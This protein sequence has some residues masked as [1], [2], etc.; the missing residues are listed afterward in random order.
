[1]PERI[2]GTKGCAHDN[3][4][5]TFEF[6]NWGSYVNDEGWFHQHYTAHWCPDHIPEW[7]SEWAGKV[8]PYRP[9]KDVPNRERREHLRPLFEE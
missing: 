7:L 4:G 2:S 5:R 1:M 8:K 3:C 9:S 6:T